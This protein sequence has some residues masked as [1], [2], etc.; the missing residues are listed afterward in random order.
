M[1]HASTWRYPADAWQWACGTIQSRGDLIRTED[2]QLTREVTNLMVTVLEPLAGWPIP[3]SDWG[4]PRLNAYVEKEILSPI[5]PDGFRYSYGQRLFAYPYEDIFEST[6][7]EFTI[8]QIDNYVIPKLKRSPETRRA[9]ATTW[10]PMLDMNEASV[11]CL[12]EVIFLIRG[13]KLNCTAF[14]RSWDCK[15]AGPANMYGLA[16]LMQY[17]AEAV[18]T[19]MGSLTIIAASAHVYEP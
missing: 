13:G 3:N 18:G 16:K 7:D 15:R 9:K 1:N 6:D 2:N 12:Q 14:F 5:V 11:P 4:L 19:S 17:V 10:S 8:N